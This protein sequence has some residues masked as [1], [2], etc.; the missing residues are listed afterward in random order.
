[1]YKRVKSIIYECDRSSETNS[2][3]SENYNDKSAYSSRVELLWPKVI[4][5]KEPKALNFCGVMCRAFS[6]LKKIQ[7]L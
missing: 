7:N 4:Y 6:V 5:T 3:Q 1:M 2:Q